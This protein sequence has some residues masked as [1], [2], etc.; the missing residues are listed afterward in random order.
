MTQNWK[1]FEANVLNI[2]LIW[3]KFKSEDNK[4]N[5]LSFTSMMRSL[6]VETFK[7]KNNKRIVPRPISDAQ[8]KS[9]EAKYL[10]YPLNSCGDKIDLK[11][12][13]PGVLESKTE[14]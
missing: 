14:C 2:D 7:F 11:T 3:N 8:K 4:M 12:Y 5:Y 10:N 1:I 9:L 6:K 13:V